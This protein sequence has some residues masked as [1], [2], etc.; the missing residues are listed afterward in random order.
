M[1]ISYNFITKIS[2]QSSD[3]SDQGQLLLVLY[4]CATSLFLEGSKFVLL[5]EDGF[6]A[7]QVWNQKYDVSLG[8]SL[9]AE[10]QVLPEKF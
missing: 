1:F 3:T 7:L 8:V 6:V 2:F 9:K 4:E 5:E 10:H